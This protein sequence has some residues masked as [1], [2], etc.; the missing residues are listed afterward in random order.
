MTDVTLVWSVS[1]ISAKVGEIFSFG[2]SNTTL[3]CISH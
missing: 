3:N 2:H 1:Q